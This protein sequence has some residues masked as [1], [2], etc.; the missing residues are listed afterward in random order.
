MGIEAE[1]TNLCVYGS[2][3]LAST[4]DMVMSIPVHY[5]HAVLEGVTRRL[6]RRWFESQYHTSPF[7]A[8]RRNRF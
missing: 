8:T 7:A 2:S 5:M 1:R 4:F 3:S 6:L